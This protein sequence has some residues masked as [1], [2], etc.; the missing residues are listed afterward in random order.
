MSLFTKACCEAALEITTLFKNIEHSKGATSTEVGAGGDV[1]LEYD[2]LAERTFVKHLSPF[3]KIYSEEGGY[4]GEGEDLIVLDPVDG[5]DNIVSNFPYFGASVALQ[6]AGK[7]SVGFVCNFANGEYFVRE[8]GVFYK[9]NLATSKRVDVEANPFA[10]VGLFEK[11][12]QH[13]EIAQA[14]VKANLK[15]RAPGAVALSLAYAHDVKYMIFVGK[16]RPYDVAAGLFLCED[17]YQYIDDT[18]IIVSHNK[19]I[20]AKILRIFNL[21]DREH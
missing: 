11:A 2:L 1:S 16:S 4:I 17:L 20:F 3:G 7:T 12:S 15:F 19:D 9:G 14:L 10:K 5:S 18:C 21:S 13:S 8:K 6:V